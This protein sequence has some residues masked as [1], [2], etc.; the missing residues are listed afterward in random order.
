M[1]ILFV[2]SI[3]RDKFGGGEKWM[4][5]AAKELA[6]R[7][8]NVVLGSKK[9]SRTLHYAKA[10]GVKTTIFEIRS[11]ISPLSTLKVAAFLKR[12]A[13]DVLICN[14]N[15]DVRVAGLAAQ[16]VQTPIV[17]ARHG[18]LL[19]DNKWKHKVTL[20]KLVDGIITN[21]N[22]IKE[23]Y[24]NYGW[25]GD[26]FVK[27]I[28]NGIIIPEKIVAHDFSARF[29]G[30]KIIYSA[31]RLSEQKGF[32]YLIETA[33]ILKQTRNDLVFAISGEGKLEIDLKKQVAHAGLADSFIFMGFTDNIYPY[34]KGCDLFVLASLFE[35]MPNVV[36]EAMAMK[37]AVI[38][39]DVNGAR[40][41]MVD[42]KTGI[43][44]P[45]K[46]PAA[47]ACAIDKII[48]NPDMLEEFGKAGY[49]RVTHEFTMT[50]MG[51][52][53]EKHLQEKIVAKQ[54]LK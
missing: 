36:M 13:I 28:Y 2:N 33:A 24:K 37:K 11:D 52:K 14:L 49:E 4:I 23:S 1:N 15:K 32:T 51:N 16:I 10:N 25:F 47:L 44:V 50:A 8:H 54:R 9:N 6:K 3:G 26:N 29:P 38:A 41:L 48:D 21:S 18:M 7:G 35:G 34:L 5:N 12:H 46:Q 31:G 53:L 39:T 22:T 45:P 19:C 27:V 20:T 42:G 40:E 17:L 43:I 30:K